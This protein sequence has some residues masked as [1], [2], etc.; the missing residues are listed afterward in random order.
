MGLPIQ[1][2][3]LGVV[4]VVIGGVIAFKTIAANNAEEKIDLA[5]T[6]MGIPKD[7]IS[8]D[9]SVDLLGFATHIEDIEMKISEKESFKIDEIVINDIDTEHQKP[10]Y[11]NVEINGIHGDTKS[12][13]MVDR[14]IARVLDS[15]NKDELITNFALNYTFDKDAKV[16]NL[17]NLSLDVEDMGT[18]SL[19]TKFH[20]VQSVENAV[21]S[22]NYAKLGNSS[23]TYE[24]SSLANTLF[25]YN[26]KRSGQDLDQFKENIIKDINKEIEKAETKEKDLEVKMLTAMADF[27]EDPE[28]IEFS[29]DPEE[30][31]S[32][33][34]LSRRF[35]DET[36]LKTLNFDI[37]VN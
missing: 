13:K 4:G 18:L 34:R 10:E 15:M 20:N 7:K 19:A 37:S 12:L 3:R 36:T 31:I 33:N 28:S 26:A 23:L 30:P 1:V 25:A 27:V 17:K 8:Y 6:N 32:V 2:I 35:N 22:F 16:L 29:M 21:A 14:S 24:D 5:I 11:L 9:V